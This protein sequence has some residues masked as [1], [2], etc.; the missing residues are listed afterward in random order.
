[1]KDSFKLNVVSAIDVAVCLFLGFAFAAAPDYFTNGDCK[2]TFAYCLTALMTS[3]FLL[4]M[5]CCAR[6]LIRRYVISERPS[7]AFGEKIVS[8]LESR[9]AILKLAFLI[10][11]F[12]LP[13]LLMLYPGTF[14]NDTWGQ[15][16]QYAEMVNNGFDTHRLWSG[17]P[18]FDTLFIGTVIY[19]VGVLT[20][21][22]HAAM[23]A[24]VIIQA[25]FTCIA[26][27]CTV[28]YAYDK[29]KIGVTAV[30][31]MLG[32]Y[33]L[34]PVFPACAQNISKD[35]IFSWIYVLFALSFVELTRTKGEAL[36]RRS[37]SLAL[38]SLAFLC[39]FTKK[40]GLFVIILSLTG[41]FFAVKENKKRVAAMLMW[42]LCAIFIVAPV[43]KYA[44]GISAARKSEIFSIP[45]QQTA[46]YVKYYQQEIPQDEYAA[47]DKLLDMKT[48]ATRYVPTNADSVKGFEELGG[49]RDYIGYVK[50]WIKQGLRH[51]ACYVSAFNAMASGWFSHYIALPPMNM[52]WHSQLNPKVLPEKTAMRIGIAKTSGDAYQEYYKRLYE[53]P[54]LHCIFTY[55]FYASLLPGFVFAVAF[56]R[57]RRENRYLCLGIIPLVLS[58]V[59]GCWFCPVSV[60][61]EG[62]RYLF[63]VIYTLPLMLAY[64]IYIYKCDYQVEARQYTD[65]AD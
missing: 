54:V 22:W 5:F 35:A 59:I 18:V 46:R 61:I 13:S 2:M 60:H 65:I 51:P 58:I 30:T 53:V 47:I 31:V 23:F 52:N 10:F 8:V 48:L 50:V 3:F 33:C 29:L 41:A 7:N 56:R 11:V 36:S 1:M 24:Y 16:Q 34:L 49:I 4:L 14:S 37:F 6:T 38:F 12:W 15:L 40:A 45:F 21:E 27:S 17:N 42:L 44:L 43:V 19:P 9:R 63:P 26:F 28:K 62:I 32:V 57:R 39:C 55:G 64:V 25:A 20:G